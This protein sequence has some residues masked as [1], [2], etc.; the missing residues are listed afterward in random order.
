[1]ELKDRITQNFRITTAQVAHPQSHLT[2]VKR[3]WMCWDNYEGGSVKG[4]KCPNV[5]TQQES[6]GQ[7][8]APYL[9]HPLW[10]N[11]GYTGS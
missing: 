10:F 3:I 2:L 1:M 6:Q 7:T 8:W 11:A 9:P 5:L 4:E